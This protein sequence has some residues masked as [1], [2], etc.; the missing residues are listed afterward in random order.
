MDASDPGRKRG[1][2]PESLTERI[3]GTQVGWVT[4]ATSAGGALVDYAGNSH[5]PLP[6]RSAIPL[7][8]EALTRAARERQGAILLFEDG[9]PCLPLLMGLIHAPSKTPLLDAVLEPPL[10]EAPMDAQ[11]DGQRVVIEGRD[12]VVLRCG[13]AS[14]TLRRNGQVLLRGINIRTEADEVHKI[15]G[16]KVQIN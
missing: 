3:L 7:D 6:A 1:A 12:E 13:K 14:L 16:G 4:G 2:P 11:V 15:K 5:G 8:R 10:D 9:D